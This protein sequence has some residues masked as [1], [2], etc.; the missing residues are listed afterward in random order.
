MS[1]RTFIIMA[2]IWWLTGITGVLVIGTRAFGFITIED[3][4]ESFIVGFAGPVA[5]TMYLWRW[6]IDCNFLNK[7]IWRRKIN[8]PVG[9]DDHQ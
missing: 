9:P 3:L 2:F 6:L 5:V 1:L 8:K 4:L 7:V